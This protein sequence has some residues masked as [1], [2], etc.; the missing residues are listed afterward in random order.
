MTGAVHPPPL[1]LSISSKLVL[2]TSIAA[3]TFPFTISEIKSGS[4]RPNLCSSPIASP[5]AHTTCNSLT[6][7][8]NAVS[9]FSTH[10]FISFGKLVVSSENVISNLLIFHKSAFDNLSSAVC[11]PGVNR[12]IC[13]RSSKSVAENQTVS[14]LKSTYWYPSAAALCQFV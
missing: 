12:G 10:A 1:L 11:I 13:D 2:A 14:T 9:H 5:Q 8:N 6:P 7:G 3:S 4:R